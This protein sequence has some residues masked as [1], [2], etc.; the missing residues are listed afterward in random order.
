VNDDRDDLP[1]AV[2][3]A[4]AALAAQPT[5]VADVRELRRDAVLLARC[6]DCDR[7]GIAQVNWRGGRPMLWTA[8]PTRE[9]GRW[10]PLVGPDRPDGVAAWCSSGRYWFDFDAAGWSEL[11]KSRAEGVIELQVDHTRAMRGNAKTAHRLLPARLR[12]SQ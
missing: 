1:P 6:V 3:R 12:P 11:P 4:L 10:W 9:H 5:E 8:G 7:R 2:R